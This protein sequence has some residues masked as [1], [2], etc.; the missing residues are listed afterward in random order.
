LR[1]PSYLR[2]PISVQVRGVGSVGVTSRDSTGQ[3]YTGK[4]MPKVGCFVLRWG[5][6]SH[7][8]LGGIRGLVGLV[9]LVGEG[10]LVGSDWVWK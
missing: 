5:L 10:G 7:F 4:R 8:G 1:R 9:G 6:W 3:T 2:A